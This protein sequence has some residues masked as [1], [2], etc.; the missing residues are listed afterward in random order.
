V[1]YAMDQGG[2][3]VQSFDHASGPI[4]RAACP[5]ARRGVAVIG[6]EGKRSRADA[7]IVA[8]PIEGRSG[9]CTSR[10]RHC[11]LRVSIRS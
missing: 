11:I 5:A 9:L 7:C 4:A 3:P 2:L 1:Q 6:G 10:R 8:R